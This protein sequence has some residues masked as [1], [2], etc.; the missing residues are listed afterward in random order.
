MGFVHLGAPDLD[1]LAGYVSLAR[2]NQLLPT[3]AEEW[4]ELLALL[5][6]FVAREQYPTAG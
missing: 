5:Q 6:E 3:Q 1:Q 4:P 2:P